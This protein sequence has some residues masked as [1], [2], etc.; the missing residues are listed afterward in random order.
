MR[1][2]GWREFEG[3]TQSQGMGEGAACRCKT[4]LLCEGQ[5][6]CSYGGMAGRLGRGVWL[7]RFEM[8]GLRL[9]Q[10]GTLHATLRGRCG[11]DAAMAS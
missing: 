10:E 5:H 3:R 6:H 4:W 8:G 7:G 9:R 2:V 11:F 1:G